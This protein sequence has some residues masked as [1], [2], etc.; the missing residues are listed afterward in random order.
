MIVAM[1]MFKRRASADRPM[2]ALFHDDYL[3]SQAWEVRKKQYFSKYPKECSVCG[4]TD[5]IELLHLSHG[6]Y[7]HERDRDLVVLCTKHRS[8][9]EERIRIEGDIGVATRRFF[10]DEMPK[11]R[12]RERQKEPRLYDNYSPSLLLSLQ[13]TLDTI[14]RPIWRF[15]SRIFRW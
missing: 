15:Y 10:E 12:D 14:S 9:L 3:K 6:N 13:M 8:A 11:Y 5:G 1:A 4:E 2:E 7:G